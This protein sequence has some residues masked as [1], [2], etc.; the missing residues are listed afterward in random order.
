MVNG[1]SCVDVDHYEA[2]GILKAAGSSISMRVQREVILICD[3][4]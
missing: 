3:Y 4:I 1:H 2:V